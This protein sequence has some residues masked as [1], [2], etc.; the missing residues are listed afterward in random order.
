MGDPP[1]WPGPGHLAA[2]ARCLGGWGGHAGLPKITKFISSDT[3][4]RKKWQVVFGCL[5]PVCGGTR[6]SKHANTLGQ[7]R[8]PSRN[9]SPPAPITG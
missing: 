8:V 4:K 3:G 5:E 9:W 2:W 1:P 6:A 7:A